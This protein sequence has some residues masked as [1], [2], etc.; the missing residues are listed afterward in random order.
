VSTLADAEART[1]PMAAVPMAAVIDAE[2]PTEQMPAVADAEAPTEQM[3]AVADA[4]SPT[5]PMPAVTSA[6]IQTAAPDDASS[7]PDAPGEVDTSGATTARILVPPVD[8]APL[9]RSDVDGAPAA[10][11]DEPSDG[12]IREHIATADTA[13]VKRRRL[14]S[15][16]PED[17]RPES[18][19]GE[20]TTRRARPTSEPRRSEPTILVGDLAAVHLA[21]AEIASDQVTAPAIDAASP[22]L[23][24]RVADLR[25][26]A[27]AFSDTEE[28]FFRDGHDED[29]VIAPPPTGESF[30]DLD[31]DYQPVR[32]WDRLRG[33]APDSADAAVT[34]V[35]TDEPKPDK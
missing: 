34:A 22:A 33:K 18:T 7:V 1:E 30:D 12:V 6:E 31:S 26:D 24:E 32:F 3:P 19:S 35:A 28:A 16:P 27:A 13:P 20:I 8:A 11:D 14:P 29:A 5:E 4:E 2:A 9:D 23:A 21:V 17:D 10:I 25:D 15:D